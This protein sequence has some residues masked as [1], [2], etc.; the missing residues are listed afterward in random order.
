MLTED[1]VNAVLRAKEDLWWLESPDSSAM[2]LRVDTSQV[3]SNSPIE[4]Y[5][6]W[7]PLGVDSNGTLDDKKHSASRY[8]FSVFDGHAG[9]MCA[10]QLSMRLGTMLNDTDLVRT[11]KQ[12]ERDSGLEWDQI[13]LAL[14]ATFIN[15]D[16]E[17]VHGALAKYR[18]VQDLARMDELLGPAVSG[19]CGLVAVVDTKANEVAVGNAG[20]SRA[21]LGVRLKD[22]RWKAVRLSE[23]QTVNNQNEVA[24]MTREH[25]G[26]STV[27]QRGRVLGGL[28]PLRAFGDCR[29]KWPLE[30][31][32]DLFPVLFSR[33]HRY[34]TTP[35]NYITPP[36]IT[37]KPVIVKH[38]LNENDKFLVMASDGLYD[39]LSDDEVVGSVAQ[40]YEANNGGK[41]GETTSSLFTEDS[42]A[43]THLIRTALSTDRLGRRS[44]SII[45]HLLAI[46]APHSRR[47]RDDISVTIV[48]FNRD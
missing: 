40:W 9:F 41:Q 26:E 35:P 4:D 46:P 18:K 37:A 5:L 17:L 13:P 34:A 12:L 2:R 33:G 15:M 47:F 1:E 39:Q 42:N 48:T 23:D 31:Q 29:Y 30:A 25:P 28:I 11:I 36:Y 19:S 22:G 10:E 8:M 44:D 24:R 38:Q 6:A 45:R 32:Q 16:N 7:M 20:D 3:S 21:L 27:I 43:A 14:T